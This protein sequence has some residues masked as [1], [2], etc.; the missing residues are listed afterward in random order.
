MLRQAQHKTLSFCRRVFILSLAIIFLLNS[1]G[2][3]LL[4]GAS[5]AAKIPSGLPSVG[6]EGNGGP[7]PLKDLSA[8][9]FALPRELGYIQESSKVPD[10]TKTVVHIQDAHCNYAAQKTISEI[11]NYLTTEYGVSV[12]NCEGGTE[13]YDFSP[14]TAIPEKDI[15]EKT[16]NFFVKEG[17]V[18]AAEYYAVNNPQ[19]VKLWGVEDADLYIKNLKI[20]R[21]SLAHED[22]IDKDLK[23]IGYMLDN[24]KRHIYPEGLLELD[25]YY[26]KYKDDKIGFKEY[27]VYLLMAA[28]KRL[29]D[30]KSYSNIYL[31][32]QT[33]DQ[34]EDINFKKANNEKDEV[35]DKLKKTLSRNKLEE[36]VAKVGELKIER[37]SQGDFYTYLVK[38]ANSIKLDLNAY[39]ELQKYIVY[40]SLY[41]AIDRAK[42]MQE[43]ESLEDR[44]KDTLYENDTQR[45]LGILSKNLAIE[46]NLFKISLTRDDYTYYKEH[47]SSF[48]VS[49]YV[50]FIDAK[51]PLYKIR[52]TL[53]ENIGV[54]DVYREK[55]EGFYECSLERDKAFI[56]NIRF[57]DHDRPN[58]II[59]TGGFHTQNLRE[60]FKK[61]KVSYISIMPKFKNPPD[62]ESP[63]LKRLAGQRTALEN[64]INTAIPAVLNLQVVEILSKLG[65]IVEGEANIRGFHFAVR[66]VEEMNRVLKRAEKV[67]LRISSKD[68]KVPQKDRPD[69]KIYLFT[70]DPD[71]I[72]V[73][74]YL[75]QAGSP[76]K[77][78][79]MVADAEIIEVSTAPYE[80]KPPSSRAQSQ[81]GVALVPPSDASVK[82]IVEPS[83]VEAPEITS[84]EA[85]VESIPDYRDAKPNM[86]AIEGSLDRPGAWMLDIA[87]A[88]SEK[89]MQPYPDSRRFDEQLLGKTNHNIHAER[90]LAKGKWTDN[91]KDAIKRNMDEFI[92]EVARASSARMVIRLMTDDKGTEISDIK[93]LIKEYLK[94]AY[95]GAEADRI[96]DK[97]VKFVP[98]NLTGVTHINA[99]VDLFVDI[100]MMEIDR[101]LNNDYPGEV[102]PQA[103]KDNFVALLKLSITNFDDFKTDDVK[104]ILDKIFNM[105][106]TL[107]IKPINWNTVDQWRKANQALLQS[108]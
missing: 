48:A 107:K 106:V 80:I 79:A 77:T 70:K 94:D 40:I 68:L 49:N 75:G 108:V 37:I 6:L 67:I 45:E 103:L 100:G 18:S 53:D 22:E 91:L 101:Y 88:L 96:I 64:V 60:L 73:P 72:I 39:P 30:I 63:Y 13:S 44:L 104:S 51:A 56:K 20:Y 4:I 61:E 19:K 92:K 105:G 84:A 76:E 46:K 99:P 57:T 66:I 52:P 17:V 7:T 58:S 29:I 59:I 85:L 62:Y 8:D 55:M 27:I 10:S 24:L 32:S 5:W 28:G 36:L 83:T 86:Q 90:Y 102:L 16:A 65:I 9:T 54:L 95:T 69:D 26:T 93:N 78:A 31:L 3:D 41:S 74:Q 21:E 47:A 35:V 82:S 33:L 23:S 11:L 25:G 15:R 12:V 50:K 87:P 43:M 34:E 98:V 97:H 42:I 14:F 71:G 81:A 38:K 1:I 89:D 2:G